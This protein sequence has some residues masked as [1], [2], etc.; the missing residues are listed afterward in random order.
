MSGKDSQKLQHSLS[1]PPSEQGVVQSSQKRRQ[2]LYWTR[3]SGMNQV[4]FVETAFKKF[5]GVW[6]ASSRPYH[7]KYFKGGLPQ[8]LLGPFL[9]TLSH[10]NMSTFLTVF[11]ISNL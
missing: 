2:T 6:S 10:I 8:I 5:E 3:Y 4:K 9:N 1:K 11:P 7:F